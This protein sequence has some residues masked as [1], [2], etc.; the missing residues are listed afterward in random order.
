VTE[1]LSLGIPAMDETHDEFIQLLS[2]AQTAKGADFLTAFEALLHHT[3]V[4]FAMEEALMREHGFYGMQEH[5]D[6]HQTLLEEMRYFYQK[7][8]KAAAFGRAYI[9]QYA[10][11]KFHR[12]VINIDSQLAMFL[13][14]NTTENTH[15]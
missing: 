1:N 2:T 6:E 3:E 9:D 8:Q 11:D 10:F 4:H 14:T 7:A 13:K 15:V 12:H 5:F